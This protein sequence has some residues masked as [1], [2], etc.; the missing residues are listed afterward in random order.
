[1]MFMADSERAAA[2]A[3]EHGVDAGL[4]L[5]LSEAFT[6]GNAGADLQKHHSRIMHFLRNNR[7]AQMIY[8]PFLAS[9]FEYVVEAQLEE[10]RRLFGKTPARIDG[11]HHLHLAANVVFGRLLPEGIVVRRNFHFDKGEKSAWNRAYRGFIDSV[12]AKRHRMAD[13]LFNIK[14]FEP[15]GRLQRIL[16]ISQNLVVELETHPADPAEYELLCSEK[17]LTMLGDVRIA[18]GFDLPAKS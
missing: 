18:E 9:S 12:M 16:S 7:F 14:P 17:L 2:M 8:N 11:H 3:L 5:N 1:M 4:H 6:G 13:I 10:Y 15:G